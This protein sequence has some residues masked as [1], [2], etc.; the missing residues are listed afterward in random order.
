MAT[1]EDDDTA[2]PDGLAGADEGP[3]PD[4]AVEELGSYAYGLVVEGVRL[5]RFGRT[6]E[7]EE[8]FREAA[9]LGDPG[10]M[11]NCGL[12]AERR[13]DLPLAQRY[14]TRAHL[15]GHPEA[16]NNLGVLLHNAGDPKALDWFRTAEAMGHPQAAGN[17]R[18]F[19][20]MTGGERPAA[21][22]P[23]RR[24]R[25]LRRPA[26]PAADAHA[27]HRDAEAAYRVFGLTGKDA[28]LVRA[29]TLA[30]RAVE[31]ASE[32]DPLRAEMLAALRDR[33]RERYDLYGRSVDLEEAIATAAAAFTAV[34]AGDS[35]RPLAAQA[36]IAVLALR[37]EADEEPGP[38]EWAVEEV[39]R[40]VLAQPGGD[41]HG[42]MALA[43]SVCGALARLAERADTD[44]GL[45]DAVAFGEQAV[46]L[47]PPGGAL[48]LGNLGA[49]LLVRGMRRGSLD[50]LNAAVANLGAARVGDDPRH[51][52]RAATNLASALRARADLTGREADRRAAREQAERVGQGP[53]TAPEHHP[54]TLIAAA[55]AA[56]GPDTAGVVRRALEAAPPGHAR[57]PMLLAR[58]AELLDAAGDR[59]AAVAAAREAAATARGSLSRLD[60]HRTLGRMLRNVAEEAGESA[61]RAEGAGEPAAPGDGPTDAPQPPADAYAT[62]TEA[63][64]AFT[65][66]VEAC[67]PG[68]IAYSQLTF[69]LAAALLTRH[70]LGGPGSDREAAL[71]ALRR[72]ARAP[73]SSPQDRLLATRFWAGVAWE[74]GDAEDA[75]AGSVV[76]VRLVQE[77]GW[78]GLDRDDQE[79][80]LRDGAAM[81]REAAAL[82]IE[83]GRPELA[84]ELLEQGRS[85]LWRAALQMRGD[86]AA[87]SARESG[88]AA[89]LEQI[90]S[91]LMAGTATTGGTRRPGAEPPDAGDQLGAE[92][93][94]T[95]EQLG[96]EALEAEDQPG[97]EALDAEARLR[98]GTRWAHKLAQ[99]RALQG[100]EDFLAPP[101]FETL[102]TAAAEGPVVIVNIS[103]IRC[104]AVIVLPDRRAEVVPLKEVEMRE[105]DEIVNTYVRHREEATG[106]GAGF[107]AGERARHTAHT[108]LEWLWD[109]IVSPVLERLRALS[110]GTVPPRIWWCPTASLANA[111]LHAAGRY[112]RTASGPGGPEPVG[113]P[114]LTVSSYTTTLAALVESRQRPAAAGG[115]L[116]AVGVT[117]TGRGHAALP[118][119]AKEVAA[120]TEVLDRER[121]TVL[122][123]GAATTGAVRELLPGHACAHFACHGGLD[124][125]SPSSAGL[126]LRD[127]DLSVLDIAELRHEGAELAFLSACHTR[128]GGGNL[129]DEAIHPA[130]AFRMAGFR[131]VVA[132]LGSV[133]D[134]AAATVAAELYRHLAGPAGLDPAG[135]A[136]ALHRA[137]AAL[138]A[139]H[140]TD[141]TVWAPF[142]HDGP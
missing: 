56:K 71:D 39:G 103:S 102:A 44:S 49:A 63:V 16:A 62:A 37:F 5:E 60:A 106:P 59:T 40:P 138:R 100:F 19:L 83:T 43:A 93:L 45:D 10:G 129:M 113:L 107:L 7:A 134:Q 80:S 140:P 41:P 142:V 84:V 11:Y 22:P 111:P 8:L 85:V 131:H 117:D 99:A 86:L 33:L 23:R 135:T 112:P 133:N 94:A 87:L 20:A 77:F 114:F 50:D 110:G 61:D 57:R 91:A 81:P 132:T 72:A 121:L 123:D 64:D 12:L 141:P 13:G 82:A 53:G 42:R 92:G 108:T 98:L 25:L 109:R 116:L 128:V 70:R 38:L 15:G 79:R 137:V 3:G 96:A 48:A 65:A 29:V 78:M 90:R 30:R 47:A 139:D 120:L 125:T 18:A 52:V 21:Q 31:A 68:H 32:R 58:L 4:D 14:Y 119:V 51:A 17:V 34:P 76:A 115:R 130:G 73:G 9:G 97:A 95:G 55:F 88:L 2:G 46:A 26:R 101:R 67:P 104:D 28:S 69:D 74:A 118:G 127:G 35:R 126:C 89:E 54:E 66:A 136:E 105:T 1:D 6:A 24:W 124:M 27:L 36:L 75:L 122:L